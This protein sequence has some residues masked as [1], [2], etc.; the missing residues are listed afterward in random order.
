V[1]GATPVLSNVSFGASSLHLDVPNGIYQGRV[2]AT[3]SKTIAIDT[4]VLR[5][6]G[7]AVRTLVAVDAVGGGAPFEVIALIDRD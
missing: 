5:E 7:G 3:G 1:N 6:R 2:T 4:P